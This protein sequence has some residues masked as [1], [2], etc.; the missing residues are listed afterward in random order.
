VIPTSDVVDE[1]LTEVFAQLPPRNNPHVG[2]ARRHLREW[3]EAVGLVRSESAATRFESANFAGFAAQTY[4][5]AD[6]TALCLVADWFGWLFLLDDQ[7]DD[8]LVGRD[9]NATQAL[10]YQLAAVLLDGET[11]AQSPIA[12]AL[13]DLWQ[14]TRM[15]ASA[16]WRDRF[17][18]HMTAGCAA[19]LWETT[20][21][22]AGVIPSVADYVANRRH[23]GAIYVC[24]D[25][26]DVV[27]G[28]EVPAEVYLE[29]AFQQVLT[30]ACDVVCWTNDLYSLDKE[31]GLGEVH[32]LVTVVE[33][34]SGC[35]RDQAVLE[36]V[37]AV[38]S[39]LDRFLVG[40][41]VLA[42]RANPAIE[43]ALAGMR[44]WTRGNFDWSSATRRYLDL[45]LA[46]PFQ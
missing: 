9:L 34:H 45:D 1:A 5:D 24:M 40:A 14:R 21:R 25:L 19:A 15:R 12:A 43:V 36:V 17:T 28:T 6:E 33:H 44:S 23:T 20:N 3:V 8:G 18:R 46:P 7:L 32:N 41:A 29:P 4:P 16:D 27:T 13:A 22:I 37:G 2:P 42:R 31:H 30:A 39:E 26:V 38:D 10:V 35:S 11:S